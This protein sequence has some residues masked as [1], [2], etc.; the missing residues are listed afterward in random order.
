MG[1][2]RSKDNVFCQSIEEEAN[3]KEEV[4]QK[5]SFNFTFSAFFIRKYTVLRKEN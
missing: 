2:K 3:L 4:S 5:L 1:L